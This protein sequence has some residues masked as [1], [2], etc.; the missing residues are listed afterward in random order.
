MVPSRSVFV[1]VLLLAGTAALGAEHSFESFNFPGR[2]IRHRGFLGYIDPVV[3]PLDE[4][5]STFKVVQALAAPNNLLAVSFE[6]VNFPGYYLRHQ[7]FRIKL[8]SRDGSDLFD[9]DATFIVGSGN[10]DK[11]NSSL[12]SFKSF[13]FP[14]RYIR[15][16]GFE[17]W[18]EPSDSALAEADSTFKVV[19]P[20]A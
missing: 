2:F 5:D 12:A 6:S 13:N 3:T 20:N 8:N 18:L 4:Q 9:K 11:S 19:A 16:R 15:H 17:L 1:F 7:N 14:R 10:A